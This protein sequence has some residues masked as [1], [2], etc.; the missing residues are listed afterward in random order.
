MA[1]LT[2][3]LA[4]VAVTLA[5]A[6]LPAGTAAARGCGVVREGKYGLSVYG[7][8]RCPFAR[9]FAQTLGCPAGWAQYALT[10]SWFKPGSY[11]CRKSS[12]H[13]TVARV[14]LPWD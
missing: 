10:R 1:R 6:L 3:V 8:V 5:L 4:F 12:G 9:P 2:I 11:G 7:E 13:L 14:E